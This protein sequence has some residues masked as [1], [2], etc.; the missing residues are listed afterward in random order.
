[1]NMST[2]DTR[3]TVSAVD[4]IGRF[5]V[6]LRLRGRGVGPAATR[7]QSEYS[8]AGE[9]GGYPLHCTH[10]NWVPDLLIRKAEP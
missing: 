4:R 3:T 9:D 7:R 10:H 1:M 2:P 6:R 5:G 8:Y